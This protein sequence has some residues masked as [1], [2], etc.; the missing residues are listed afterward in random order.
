MRRPGV[1]KFMHAHDFQ[2]QCQCNSM[3]SVFQS[4]LLVS[5]GS[6]PKELARQFKYLKVENEIL[7]G[8]LPKRITVT[9][10]EK[11]RQV[12]FAQKLG[13]KILRQLLAKENQWGYTC[14]LGEFKR[15]GFRSISRNT[16][17]RIQ[18][19]AAYGPGPK[20]GEG[21]CVVTHDLNSVASVCT[22]IISLPS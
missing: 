10:K 4:L 16:V 13:G 15:L 7:R 5:A 22:E 14:I 17:K 20:R 3:N 1:P 9:P 6:T 21:T 19:D 18:K 2:R 8:K 11:H 12:R